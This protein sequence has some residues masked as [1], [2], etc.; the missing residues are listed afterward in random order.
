MVVN[1]FREAV[2]TGGEAPSE[3]SFRTYMATLGTE[4]RR[5]ERKAAA[6]G[7][8]FPARKAIAAMSNTTGGELF[9]GVS[10][11]PIRLELPGT[12]ATP[13]Q[14]TQNFSQAKA[15]KETWYVV[16]LT[17]VCAAP[18]VVPLEG[19]PEVVYV[20]EVQP[21]GLPV[22]LYR[23]DDPSCAPRLDLPIRQGESVI[24]T[25]AAGAMGW[26]RGNR[27]GKILLNLYREYKLM[28]ERLN[29]NRPFLSGIGR[30]LP[31]LTRVM[32][33]GSF[34]EYLEEKDRQML[35]GKTTDV[36]ANAGGFL[37]PL[38]D[39][40]DEVEHI[41]RVAAEQNLTP[42]RRQEW[43]NQTVMSLRMTLESNLKGFR[44]ELLARGIAVE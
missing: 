43:V 13:Q 36:Y 5:S 10:D 1:S 2:A 26:L 25:D 4:W 35:L 30:T 23:D 6:L 11:D 44:Q 12:A 38:L 16:D 21:A 34:Y 8:D 15:P 24:M 14:L 19:K 27:R 22:L 40:Q 33:D 42:Q 7:I 29:Q 20:L 9:L 37:T 17:T 3:S 31:Y 41:Y 18:I 39:L 32:E 28:T